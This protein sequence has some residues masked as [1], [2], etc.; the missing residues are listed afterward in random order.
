MERFLSTK[1]IITI[2]KNPQIIT[3]MRIFIPFTNLIYNNYDV[4]P[5]LFFFDF[6]YN[7]NQET[8]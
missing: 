4:I 5:D 3:D 8:T 1:T 6:V 7:T 2:N